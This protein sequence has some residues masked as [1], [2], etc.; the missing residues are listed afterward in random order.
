MLFYTDLLGECYLK[1]AILSIPIRYG[2]IRFSVLACAR[3]V[4]FTY[5]CYA[6]R[7]SVSSVP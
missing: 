4:V 1:V 6:G 2:S 5:F 7:I 3:V